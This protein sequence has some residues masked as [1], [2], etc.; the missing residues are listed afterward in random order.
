[1]NS[2]MR[3]IRDSL[4]STQD[5]E[6]GM[7]HGV[8]GSQ[9]GGGAQTDNAKSFTLAVNFCNSSFACASVCESASVLRIQMF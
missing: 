4:V 2:E 1:M 5:V 8:W 3:Q 6:W 7:G 9:L